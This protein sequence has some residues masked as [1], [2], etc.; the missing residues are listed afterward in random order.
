MVDVRGQFCIDRYEAVLVDHAQGRRLSPYYSPSREGTRSAFDLWEKKRLDSETPLGR[1]LAITP[2][3]D[4]QLGQNF[5]P[6][7]VSLGGEIPSGYVSGVLA[8]VACKNAHKRLCTG[9]EW[10]MACRGEQGRKFPYGDEYVQGRCN[11]FRA[12]HPAAELH[13]N[14]SIGHTD[15]RLN[16][17]EVDGK[18]LLR[19]TGETRD[20][21]SQWGNDG[22]FD[23]V[24]N[25]DEWVDDPGGLFLGGFYSRSTKQG[26]EARVSA[27]PPAYFDYS[28][29][30]RCCL[31]PGT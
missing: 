26:C 30:V 12:A 27:H 14:A 25:L 10:V 13:G 5:E 7:A 11:V 31:T 4:W 24:G 8:S 21:R 16:A 29:G 22:V 28:L 1:T 15:P 6:R 3:P 20:C 23:L 18:P 2:P 17:V 19:R 9:E